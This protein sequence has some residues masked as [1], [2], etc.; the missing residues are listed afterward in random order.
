LENN[1]WE[2]KM[3]KEPPKQLLL[4][5]LIISLIIAWV[6]GNIVFAEK[7]EAPTTSINECFVSGRLIYLP[8]PKT[9]GTLIDCLE[10]HESQGNPNAFNPKDI[11]GKPKYGCL[12]YGRLT[13]DEFCVEKYG[14]EDDIWNC[15]IQRLCASKM[16]AE[17]LL[18]KWGTKKY[19][20]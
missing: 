20:I 8:T 11:D 3:D 2:I 12:Q 18:G 19:C 13:F 5:V 17:G 6:I 1:L 9:Y 4:V 16:I 10:K 7:E 15:D 14:L